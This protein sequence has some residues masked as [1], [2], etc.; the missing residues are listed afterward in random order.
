MKQASMG[1]DIE[2]SFIVMK[3]NLSKGKKGELV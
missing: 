3:T 2:Y 1:M